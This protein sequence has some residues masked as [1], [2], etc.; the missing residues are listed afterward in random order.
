MKDK[1]LV[2]MDDRI[3]STGGKPYVLF[4]VSHFND[5]D[6]L[7]PLAYK[8][9]QSG[10]ACPVVLVTDLSYDIQGD[11]LLRFL[12]ERYGVPVSSALRFHPPNPLVGWLQG[13]LSKPMWGGFLKPQRL[14]VLRALRK[15]FYNKRWAERILGHYDPEVLVFAWAHP[16][17]GI[18]GAFVSAGHDRGIPCI[19]LPHGMLTFTNQFINRQEKDEGRANRDYI[20]LFESAVYQSRL[21]ARRIVE[22][23]APAEK[24]AVLGSTRYCEEWQRINLDIQ[25]ERFTP[26]KSLDFAYRTVFMLPQWDYNADFDA[27]MRTLRRLS[28]EPWLHLVIKP[29]TR[30]VEARPSY[31]K[32]LESLPNV[33][34]AGDVGSVPLIRWADAVIVVGSSIALEVL[35][36]GK[37]HLYPKYLH[38]NTTVFEE[39][40]AAWTVNDD[41]ELVEALRKLSQGQPPSYGE[42]EI[43]KVITQLVLGNS[44]ETD[45]LGSYVDF[46]LGGWKK[47]AQSEEEGIPRGTSPLIPEV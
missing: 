33:E 8:L 24:I 19:S 9:C 1:T 42:E 39:A 40:G 25:P 12:Q 26:R 7:T 47:N 17:V 5:I 2:I 22:E 37:A 31:L 10:R 46:I 21:H 35:L 34:V 43:S 18:V 29:G 11:Y 44:S 27:T 3:E 23:G 36:Q 15:V 6:H 41:E 14:F 28:S 45:V 30:E 13:L 38:D 20:G 4:F 16:A 32:E